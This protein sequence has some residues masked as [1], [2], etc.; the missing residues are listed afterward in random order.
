MKL[1]LL[2]LDYDGT[3]AENGELD[4]EV[5]S[6]LIEARR[7]DITLVLATGRILG[8]PQRLPC[9]SAETPSV[10]PVAVQVGG[11]SPR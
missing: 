4:A 9:A 3:I 2:A 7:K 5:R 8:D 1:S 11:E 10:H 6:A